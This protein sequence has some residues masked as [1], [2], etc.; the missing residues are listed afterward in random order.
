MGVDYTRSNQGIH[1]FLVNLEIIHTLEVNDQEV[2]TQVG[3]RQGKPAEGAPGKIGD[4]IVVTYLD[5]AGYL[6]RS[7]GQNNRSWPPGNA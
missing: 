5:Y 4:V 1:V 7:L 3:A 6:L 2:I